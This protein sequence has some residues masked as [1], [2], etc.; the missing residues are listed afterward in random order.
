MNRFR[1]IGFQI[2]L[3]HFRSKSETCVIIRDLKFFV[4]QYLKN[5]SSYREKALHIFYAKFIKFLKYIIKIALKIQE[6]KLR[7]I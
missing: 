4:T 3:H 6:T 5:G 2:I 1:D 7:G